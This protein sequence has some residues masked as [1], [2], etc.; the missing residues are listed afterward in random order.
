MLFT[1]FSTMTVFVGALSLSPCL[2][3]AEPD[4]TN[5]NEMEMQERLEALEHLAQSVSS[6]T[7]ERK[8]ELDKLEHLKQRFAALAEIE[9]SIAQ[10]K[11]SQKEASAASDSTKDSPRSMT[12]DSYIE[13]Q[14][15]EAMTKNGFGG[16]VNYNPTTASLSVAPTSSPSSDDDQV[17]TLL[18]LWGNPVHPSADI[19]INGRP[20]DIS[21]GSNING[22]KVKHITEAYI[23]V[24][25]GK[26]SKKLTF[27]N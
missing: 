22:W 4:E 8:A 11:A 19:A 3:A 12:T 17:Y 1:K 6:Q 18:S 5:V 23:E 14:I 27:S 2:T 9:G 7:L 16:S 26:V 24:T 21:A 10:I 13:E 25:K 20:I 15:K